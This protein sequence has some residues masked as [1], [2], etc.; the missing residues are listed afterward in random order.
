MATARNR[1]ITRLTAELLRIPWP[2]LSLEVSTITKQMPVKPVYDSLTTEHNN[3]DAPRNSHLV[4]PQ[5]CRHLTY[6]GG[7]QKAAH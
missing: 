6:K 5:G 7:P 2:R 3:D 4:K 1:K